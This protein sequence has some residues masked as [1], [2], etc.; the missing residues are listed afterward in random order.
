M[1][2]LN[3]FN[4]D[5]KNKYESFLRKRK[6]FIE[7]WDLSNRNLDK[8]LLIPSYV[9]RLNI[10]NN[11]LKSLPLLPENLEIL[12]CNNNQLTSL[13]PLPESLEIL[14]CSYNRLTSLSPTFKFLNLNQL[15]CNNNQLTSLPPLPESLEILDCSYNRIKNINYI[16][17]NLIYLNC[18]HNII[19][20]IYPYFNENIKINLV[21][22]NVQ[23][24]YII[25]R[26]R[27]SFESL[28]YHFNY[29]NNPIDEI[30]F[31][32]LINEFNSD[33]EI[34]SGLNKLSYQVK[35]INF[36]AKGYNNIKYNEDIINREIIF[37]SDKVKTMILP[38]GTVLF[39]NVKTTE[40]ILS[41]FLGNQIDNF[42]Y[43][44][45]NF[46]YF[47]YPYPFV[48]DD[49]DYQV[50]GNYFCMFVLNEDTEIILGVNPS[51]NQRNDKNDKEYAVKCNQ[52]GI[53]PFN[54]GQFYDIC[55]NPEFINENSNI[56]GGLFIN[57][58]D[59]HNQS[60]F[61]NYK[62]NITQMRGNFKD[63][64]DDEGV[65]E[66]ILHPLKNRNIPEYR[67]EKIDNSIKPFN[68]D[69]FFEI[70][71]LNIYDY[72]KSFSD[73][74]NYNFIYFG[75]DNNI[76]SQY[77]LNMKLV[78]DLLSPEGAIL[79]HIS[80]NPLH[81]TIDKKTKFLMI[82]E[83]SNFEYYNT[84]CVPFKEHNKLRFLENFIEINKYIHDDKSCLNK[85][86]EIDFNLKDYEKYGFGNYEGYIDFDDFYNESYTNVVINIKDILF[87]GINNLF[88]EQMLYRTFCFT[89]EE[90]IDLF[91]EDYDP[92]LLK[93]KPYNH[94]NDFIFNNLD[95]ERYITREDY[96]KLFNESY[97]IFRFSCV[98]E[99]EKQFFSID[100]YT[101][102]EYKSI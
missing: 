47:F 67:S 88:Y 50:A 18:S 26:Y 73:I 54:R 22:N 13:P 24:L 43:L 94:Y 77:N 87:I 52:E 39:K 44:F 33:R 12:I 82:K 85:N 81:L 36:F 1:D 37:K 55:L 51:D 41:G 6:L 79:E 64:K 80:D 28:L 90:L 70:T 4:L 9:K 53:D 98:S 71:N 92:N 69:K 102:E 99:T 101:L 86:M 27:G 2:R 30:K 83:Y 40:K 19:E 46:N 75:G 16:S 23:N 100:G 20:N 60:T 8:I 59:V 89:R 91:I 3:I 65:P 21:S 35:I 42:Y 63:K 76:E 49:L 38:K 25:S 14:D 34:D 5:E 45:D 32:R 97:Q 11:R 10:S 48:S 84:N 78:N 68:I 96:N 29:E 7:E 93:I 17:E 15:N 74:F 95:L 62:Y 31:I 56:S 58:V 72:G 66:I 57:K 61:K